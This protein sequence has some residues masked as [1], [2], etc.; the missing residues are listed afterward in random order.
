MCLADAPLRLMMK[1]GGVVNANGKMN[2]D[3]K[4]MWK[5][6]IKT[7]CNKGL[8]ME[9]YQKLLKSKILEGQPEKHS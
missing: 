3:Y 4:T 1:K 2:Y 9:H 5:M 6:L 7:Y 8:F